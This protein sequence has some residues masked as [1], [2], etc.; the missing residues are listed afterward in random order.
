MPEAPGDGD[1][2]PESQ[3]RPQSVFDMMGIPGSSRQ[4]QGQGTSSTTERV[5][6]N[7][8]HTCLFLFIRNPVCFRDS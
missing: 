1:Q 2:Q 3:S 7:P 8:V 5:S 6:R 4:P